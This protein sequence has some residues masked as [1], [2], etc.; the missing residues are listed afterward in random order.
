ML[1]Y[2]GLG[3]N[4]GDRE[5]NLEEALG[6][7]DAVAG[8]QVVRASS[9]YDTAPVGPPQPR[10][11]N[12]VCAVETTLSPE[13]LLDA[14]HRIENDMGRR[15]NADDRWGPRS[16]DIDLLFYGDR[17]IDGE[18]LTVPHRQ[19]HKRE[20]VLRPMAEIAP[21]FMHPVIHRTMA[22]MLE[23]I[24]RDDDHDRR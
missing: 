17:V 19:A 13:E 21:D 11:L 15:R 12:A 8:I 22:D 20:F 18:R 23:D 2:L 14:I 24:T 1:V 3:G 5:S 4:T 7:L 6:R 9:F 10:F 16:I